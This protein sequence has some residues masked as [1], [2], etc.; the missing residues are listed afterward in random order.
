[1]LGSIQNQLRF[2]QAAVAAG[3]TPTI[4]EKN[5]LSA[6]VIAVREFETNDPE[7]C[8]ALC[9]AVFAFKKL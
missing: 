6:G 1:M 7:Y 2:M 4:A 8:D 3:R 9:A 5:S